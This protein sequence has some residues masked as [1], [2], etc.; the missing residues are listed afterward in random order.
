MQSW[1]AADE[2][3]DTFRRRRIMKRIIPVFAAAALITAGAAVAQ[4]GHFHGGFSHGG[5]DRAGM[6]GAG[7]SERG[8]EKLTKALDLS[9]SQ[10]TAWQQLRD[11]LKATVQPLF[12]AARQKHEAIRTGLDANA[13]A[14]TLGN[15]MIEAHAIGKQIRAAH[16]KYEQDFTALLTTEQATKYD[17]IRQQ[18][19]QFR[20][21]PGD[22]FMPPPDQ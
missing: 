16:D 15:L 22:G 8:V 6:P 14:A 5:F 9:S 13:D 4:P 10:Q 18:R 1:I 7:M 20:R 19:D 3:S 12:A 11:Q 21:G 2:R 17:A